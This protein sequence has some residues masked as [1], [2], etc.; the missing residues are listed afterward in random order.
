[1]AA[2]K[3][4]CE[5]LLPAFNKNHDE[6]LVVTY[7]SPRD[8]RN[9]VKFVNILLASF[10]TCKHEPTAILKGKKKKATERLAGRIYLQF[11]HIPQ[12]YTCVTF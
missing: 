1:V 2:P 11:K 5:I 3:E 6:I 8:L 4:C 10:Q 12:A 9:S 7:S